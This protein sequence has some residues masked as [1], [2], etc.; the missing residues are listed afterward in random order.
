MTWSRQFCRML[1]VT[2]STNMF[3]QGFRGT[4][5]TASMSLLMTLRWNWVPLMPSQSRGRYRVAVSYEKTSM[6]CRVVQ[7][8]DGCPV[9]SKFTSLRW[10]WAGTNN[11][12]NTFDCH[13]WYK[14]EINRLQI[15]DMILNRANNFSDGGFRAR[16]RYFSTINSATW[17]PSLFSSSTIG[18]EP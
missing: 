11:T 15:P 7:Y 10:W 13:G 1:P 3:C 6:I 14:K 2:C 4:N 8:A 5:S 12:S 17:I 16:T 18:S 9:I